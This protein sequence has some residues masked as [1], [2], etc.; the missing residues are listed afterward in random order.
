MLRSSDLASL[1]AAPTA[2]QCLRTA[3]AAHAL[4]ATELARSGKG[5]ADG[6]YGS[7]VEHMCWAHSRGGGEQICGAGGAWSGSVQPCVPRAACPEGAARN[8]DNSCSCKKPQY[9]G[10]LTW[11]A[12]AAGGGGWGG[13][14]TCVNTAVCGSGDAASQQTVGQE[15]VAGSIVFGGA[16]LL[17][18]IICCCR[19]Q[20]SREELEVKDT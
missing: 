5:A 16:A 7:K 2:A 20:R 4:W 19:K 6:A 18:A 12:T 14:C 17:L 13:A 10:T 9:S 15:A 8:S 11:G 1:A 3:A